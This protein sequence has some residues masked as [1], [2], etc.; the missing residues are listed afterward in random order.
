MSDLSPTSWELICYSA[1]LKFLIESWDLILNIFSLLRMNITQDLNHDLEYCTQLSIRSMFR[2]LGIYNFDR[3]FKFVQIHTFYEHF[4]VFISL[5]TGLNSV[6]CEIWLFKVVHCV[7]EM[8]DTGGPPTYLN[9]SFSLQMG[10]ANRKN[11]VFYW[12]NIMYHF[13]CWSFF[14]DDFKA[15]DIS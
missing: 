3:L 8:L 14:P 2:V 11:I 9:R 4:W 12:C 10:V 7:L 5:V 6:K 15:L 13:Y 1:E